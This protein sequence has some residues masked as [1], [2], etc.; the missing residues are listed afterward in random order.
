MEDVP[1]E[2]ANEEQLT[3]GNGENGEQIRLSL[4]LVLTIKARYCL[5]D[6]RLA[7][8]RGQFRDGMMPHLCSGS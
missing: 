8:N 6:L 4:I 5:L 3:G 1:R 7:R 2:L